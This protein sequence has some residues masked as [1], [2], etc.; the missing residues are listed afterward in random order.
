MN[1]IEVKFICQPNNDLIRDILSAMLAE[2]G[3]ESFVETE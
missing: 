3:F 1:Y 2:V